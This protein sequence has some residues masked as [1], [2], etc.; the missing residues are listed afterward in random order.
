MRVKKQCTEW[1]KIVKIHTF[2][3][4]LIFRI[5]KE[6]YVK[7]NYIYKKNN[8]SRGYIKKYK[9]NLTEKQQKMNRYITPKTAEMATKYYL[10][11]C[12]MLLVKQQ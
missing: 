5:C 9:D 3:K 2:Y 11:N 7:N 10:K 8:I 4:R 12:S 1:G 6:L